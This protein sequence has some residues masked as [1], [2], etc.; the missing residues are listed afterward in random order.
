M[1]VKELI[2]IL[3]QLPDKEACI[4]IQADQH[5]TTN[6][7]FSVDD[8]NDIQLYEISDITLYGSI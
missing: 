7:G 3:A 2:S 4:F 8:N 1:K 5:F 6:I